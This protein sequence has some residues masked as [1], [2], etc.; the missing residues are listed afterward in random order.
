[1][2]NLIDKTLFL[3]RLEVRLDDPSNR[4]YE[5]GKEFV[6]LKGAQLIHLF[7]QLEEAQKL[8]NPQ[9]VNH[10]NI[11]NILRNFDDINSFMKTLERI[12]LGYGS[13]DKN[14][15]EVPIY[16]YKYEKLSMNTNQWVIY[17]GWSYL[18]LCEV[19]TTMLSEVIKF[20][21]VPNGIGDAIGKIRNINS[22]MDL[23]YFNETKKNIRNA[24]GHISFKF[25]NEEI[26]IPKESEPLQL[27]ELLQGTNDIDMAIFVLMGVVQIFFGPKKTYSQSELINMLNLN[28]KQLQ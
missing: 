26:I 27:K 13:I 16:N 18:S 6:R 2:T 25:H 17:L 11:E 3:E 5:L 1:M 14:S 12:F 8:K 15:N 23:S 7:Q 4:F 28:N 22:K 9:D 19:M 21:S 20:A 24:F 10:S